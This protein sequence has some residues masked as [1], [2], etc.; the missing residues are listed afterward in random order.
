MASAF[1]FHSRATSAA[2]G[3]AGLGTADEELSRCFIGRFVEPAGLRRG[4]RARAFEAPVQ[5]TTAG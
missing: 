3:G 2:D 1:A 5:A 4:A